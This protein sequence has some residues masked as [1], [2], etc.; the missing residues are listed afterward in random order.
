MEKKGEIK[1][2]RVEQDLSEFS[3]AAEQLYN[4]TKDFFRQKEDKKFFAP[5]GKKDI[6]KLNLKI[7]NI[8]KKRLEK[9][10]NE[11]EWQKK[12]IEQKLGL[13]KASLKI[14]SENVNKEEFSLPE[15]NLKNLALPT[16]KDIL[17]IRQ[18]KQ[19]QEKREAEEVFS[20]LPKLNVKIKN[21]HLIERNKIT[22]EKL[23]E[24]RKK[25]S[26]LAERKIQKEI[27]KQQERLRKEEQ[28]EKLLEKREEEKKAKELKEAEKK[29]RLEEAK[30]K[31]AGKR[32]NNF[33][34]YDEFSELKNFVNDIKKMAQKNTLW[35][36][37]TLHPSKKS[38]KE[39]HEKLHGHS[40]KIQENLKKFKLNL[41]FIK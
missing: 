2:E 36:E 4:A 18:E 22:R 14:K 21:T 7:G 29:Q 39:E 23:E 30:A 1:E 12:K 41:P 27:E 20:P 15:L 19:K 16:M 25:E 11:K 5:V 24:K 26:A 32:K 38:H 8:E 33:M 34:T 40:E 10:F 3:N 13:K 31:R 37:N 35:L 17:M 9:M 6:S 28:K